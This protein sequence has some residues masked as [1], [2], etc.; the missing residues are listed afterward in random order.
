MYLYICCS[1]SIFALSFLQESVKDYRRLEPG[2]PQ[3]QPKKG[4][5]MK[6]NVTTSHRRNTKLTTNVVIPLSARLF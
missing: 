3:F 6:I 2:H 1:H 5:E 4:S